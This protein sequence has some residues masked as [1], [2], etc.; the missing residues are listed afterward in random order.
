MAESPVKT[1][2][3]I[4]E[5][6]RAVDGGSPYVTED[7]RFFQYEYRIIGNTAQNIDLA[8]R[9]LDDTTRQVEKLLEN[10]DSKK[11]MTSAHLSAW[12]A[13]YSNLPVLTGKPDAVN[14]AA[15]PYVLSLMYRQ[16][17][18][19]A[20]QAARFILEKEPDQYG[21]LLLLGIL[22]IYNRENF[23]YLE[24]AFLMNPYK[25]VCIFDWHLRQ[26]RVRQ[27]KEWDFV[28]AY[29]RMLTE[30]RDR[31]R[32]LELPAAV[33]WRL[34]ESFRAK[35]EN[36]EKPFPGYQELKPE[37]GRLIAAIRAMPHRKFP[38]ASRSRSGGQLTENGHF[39]QYR[40]ARTGSGGRT[41]E[42]FQKSARNAEELL[43]NDDSVTDA[44]YVRF[45]PK[46]NETD[47]LS[48]A[49]YSLALTADRNYEKAEKVARTVLARNPGHYGA[50]LVLGLLSIRN[51]EN[52][53]YLERA[54]VMNPRKTLCFFDWH[55]G[56]FAIIPPKDWDFVHAY[57][58]MLARHPE[59]I[60]D[61]KLPA[62]VAEH[63]SEA[64][65]SR[66]EDPEK[67]FP[68]SPDMEPEL[69]ELAILIRN[70]L[71]PEKAP[72]KAQPQ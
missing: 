55:L 40:S 66:Y 72:V 10:D 1:K 70:N 39:F 46:Y 56:Q 35:Y 53:P 17:F 51:E 59:L 31:L 58:R 22:S 49:A 15:P 42:E 32:G 5:S 71:K 61:L 45:R 65:R 2:K 14:P 4:T 12:G 24:R 60:R 69:K 27:Q 44:G 30:Y 29:F 16:K 57:F 62:A 26:F 54:F 47:D 18:K 41:P 43:A 36:P 3:I 37:M 20:E 21:A 6:R 67:P 64:F 34:S 23:P 9:T 63:L 50:S 25:T 11:I 68:G 7:G 28:H 19:E 33:S 38:S 52:F 8:I 13:L 48:A